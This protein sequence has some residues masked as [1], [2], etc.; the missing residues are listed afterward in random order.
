[1][2][3]K[4]VSGIVAT[5]IMVALVIAL[6]GVVWNAINNLVTEQLEDAGTCL[7]IQGKV[8]LER[9][10]TC[11]DS[12]K[13]QFSLQIGDINVSKVIVQIS[14]EGTTKSYEITK[15]PQPIPGLTLYNGNTTVWLPGADGGLTYISTDFTSRPDLITIYSVLGTKRCDSSSDFISE[16]SSCLLLE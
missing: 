9:R 3:R 8:K 16:I 12:G 11:Y 2:K 10:Y 6:V 1:M 5:V 4:G 14:G 7:D 13:T 15:E